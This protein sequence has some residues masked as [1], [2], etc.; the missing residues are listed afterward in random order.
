MVCS[1][2]GYLALVAAVVF[3]VPGGRPVPV[4]AAGGMGGTSYS[5]AGRAAVV[6]RWERACLLHNAKGQGSRNTGSVSGACGLCCRGA[7]CCCLP[8]D[9][10]SW[11]QCLP[12][13]LSLAVHPLAVCW[14]LS[15]AG[16][17][18]GWPVMLPWPVCLLAVMVDALL[19]ERRPVLPWFCRC[20]SWCRQCL[21]RWPVPALRIYRLL[22]GLWRAVALWCRRLVRVDALTIKGRSGCWSCQC[23]PC[24][25]CQ[26]VE[27]VGSIIKHPFNDRVWRSIKPISSN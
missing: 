27:A 13:C 22:C 23:W 25:W 8:V 17:V 18:M 9:A 12:C 21:P 1:R 26:S 16:R 15:G 10:S 6:T 14:L 4:R 5:G 2:E 7:L 11:G 3:P 19:I 20:L 24:S